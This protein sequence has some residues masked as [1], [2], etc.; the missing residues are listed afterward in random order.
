MTATTKA[1]QRKHLNRSARK[2]VA[3]RQ[4]K[5]PAD[6]SARSVALGQTLV[7]VVGGRARKRNPKKAKPRQRKHG[8][9]EI[10]ARR[11]MAIVNSELRRRSSTFALVD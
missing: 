6:L 10:L 2:P 4:S 7:R 1:V 8:P 9:A 11:V 3:N 5:V